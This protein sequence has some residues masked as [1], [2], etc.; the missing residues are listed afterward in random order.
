MKTKSSRWC[1]LISK[2]YQVSRNSISNSYFIRERK[3]TNIQKRTLISNRLEVEGVPESAESLAGIQV[4]CMTTVRKVD[5][6]RKMH[7]RKNTLNSLNLLI[8]WLK[9]SSRRWHLSYSKWL[10][11]QSRPLYQRHICFLKNLMAQLKPQ[12]RPI[13][14]LLELDF[15]IPANNSQH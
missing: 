15:H 7:I 13:V 3:P 12:L 4:G 9:T 5:R 14:R 11:M 10:N 6:R 8:P 1:R 2:R